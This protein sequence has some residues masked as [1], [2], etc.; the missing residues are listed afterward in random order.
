MKKISIKLTLDEVDDADLVQII[1]ALSR[2]KRLSSTICDLLRTRTRVGE[3]IRA[4]EPVKLAVPVPISPPED[5][6]QERMKRSRV[7][8]AFM[9]D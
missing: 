3:A 1:A 7:V 6:S 4:I 5:K 2:R 9:D 8:S